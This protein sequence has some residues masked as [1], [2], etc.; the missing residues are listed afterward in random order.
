[1]EFAKKKEF[2]SK[3]TGKPLSKHVRLPYPLI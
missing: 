2:T 1:M 3:L